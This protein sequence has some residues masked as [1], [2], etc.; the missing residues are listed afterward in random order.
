MTL[1]EYGLEGLEADALER[2]T[3][4][5]LDSDV[6]E[7]A[8][9]VTLSEVLALALIYAGK[10]VP[11]NVADSAIKGKGDSQEWVISQSIKDWNNIYT[12]RGMV[13]A[14]R[15]HIIGNVGGA[16]ALNN[17]NDLESIR[18]QT[19]KLENLQTLMN[20]VSRETGLF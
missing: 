7:G 15:S 17:T 10:E 12:D 9:S 4:Q 1:K 8:G 19:L 3:Q 13:R 14:L 20:T 6:I 16:M 18:N 2:L 5:Q 11:R